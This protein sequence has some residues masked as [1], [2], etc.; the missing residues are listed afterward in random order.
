M[1]FHHWINLNGVFQNVGFFIIR[2]VYRSKYL[3]RIIKYRYG[4]PES[5]N[6][7]VITNKEAHMIYGNMTKEAGF[8]Q[9]TGLV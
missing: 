1:K 7:S 2:T 6:A 4:H 3:K 8:S 9:A 5:F